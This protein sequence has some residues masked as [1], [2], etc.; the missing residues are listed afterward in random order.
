M[1]NKE[2]EKI[3][4]DTYR[5]VY[6]T[7]VSLLKDEDEA[8]DIVQET[9]VTL[10]NS[11]DTLKDKNKAASWLKKT[12]ANKCL[13]RLRRTRT[14]NAEDDFFENV[15]AQPEDFLPD[16]ILESD[17]KRRIIMDIINNSLS[18]D[19]RRTL[20]LFYYDEMTTK[21]IASLLGIPQG[22]VLWRLNYAKK[23]IKKEVER[24]EEDN[25]DKLYA[26]ATPF[27][28]KLFMKEAENVPLK[29][30]STV[31]P[32]L[33]ASSHG[34]S[35]AAASKLEATSAAKGIAGIATYKIVIAIVAVVLAVAVA[36]GV[37]TQ[38]RKKSEKTSRKHE[39]ET[40]DSKTDESEEK[41]MEETSTGSS[42][43]EVSEDLDTAL[44]GTWMRKSEQDD[45]YEYMLLNEDGT[46]D[47]W[48][49][50]T[51]GNEVARSTGTYTVN[52]NEMN[53]GLSDGSI[54]NTVTYTVNEDTLT[55]ESPDYPDQ[56][57]VYKRQEEDQAVTSVNT[58]S[59]GSASGLIGTW[60][61]TQDN[62][63]M[64]LSFTEEG[65][66]DVWYVNAVGQEEERLNDTY[67]VEGNE[68]SVFLANGDQASTLIYTID[69]D[70]LKLESADPPG[71][72]LILTRSD[73]TSETSEYTV[74]D[75][76]GTWVLSDSDTWLY[77]SFNEDGTAESWLVEAP[78]TERDR[79]TDTYTISGNELTL[80]YPNGKGTETF[81][82]A[83]D[84]DSLLLQKSGQPDAIL[85]FIR[86]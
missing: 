71:E 86:Q 43:S 81:I 74:S 42:V 44:L 40:A 16:H 48:K 17:E 65:T 30:I 49:L 70:T 24:Y 4:N 57:L 47:I 56:V 3:Y 72:I 26:M 39:T 82:I 79:Q 21:E 60:T 77:I 61:L 54:F 75:L 10:I 18:D 19:I 20:I 34:S 80:T 33:S 12:A 35:S 8:Q 45:T 5:S 76:L 51:D 83:I 1:D 46:I 23:K 68:I 69:G 13:D 53:M 78:D 64:Y 59:E 55:L 14:V 2:L 9:Y 15:E 27:L 63:A 73:G 67:S 85:E 58:T 41:V 62:K 37:I 38:V 25:D 84:G 36:I 11:Y 66:L 31:L 28:T 50:D 7:A 52:G 32:E 6:W 22:T 29:P